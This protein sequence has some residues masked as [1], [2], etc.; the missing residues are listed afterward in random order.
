M[1]LRA[2]ST[3]TVLL[4]QRAGAGSQ[5]A[6][7][8][9]QGLQGG[10]EDPE[11]R[12]HRPGR[13]LRRRDEAAD[14]AGHR[15]GQGARAVRQAHRRVRADQ[16]EGRPHGG[17]VLRRRVGGDDGR[18]TR[19]PG[20]RGLRGRGGDQQGLRHRGAVA[21]RRR[22]A[23]DRR[24]QRLHVRVP[25]RAGAAR[26]P[27]Q[28]HLRGHQRHPAAVHRADRDE[29]RGRAAE[30]SRGE[31]QGR[32]QRPDQGLRRA[33]RVRAAPRVAGHRHRART[34]NVH[35]AQPGAEGSRPR[36][37]RSTPGT[38]PRRP[39]ASCASTASA[40]STSSSPPSGWRTS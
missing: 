28:P 2:S 6:R 18:R 39:T 17:R 25:L 10:D 22:G 27:H 21:H 19:R 35:Q 30:G 40:S 34:G 4:R 32:L 37:S 20:L 14:R 15:A 29:R 8:G 13:R 5:R 16:A 1:G 9:G 31:P 33:R 23:A 3:T 26:L 11:Q 12:P 24:R 38:S 7:R 36:R